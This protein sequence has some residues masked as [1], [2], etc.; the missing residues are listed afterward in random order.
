MF[1]LSS[2]LNK[3]FRDDGDLSKVNGGTLYYYKNLKGQWLVEP[4][5]RLHAALCTIIRSGPQN[6]ILGG[7]GPTTLFK[8]GSGPPL[9]PGTPMKK[10]KGSKKV[11]FFLKHSMV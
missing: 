9:E 8:G 10:G 2:S 4:T 1:F 5:L 3:E 6:P 11:G 7:P